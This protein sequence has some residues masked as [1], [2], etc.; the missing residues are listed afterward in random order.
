MKP[1]TSHHWIL[2]GPWYRWDPP[3]DPVVGRQA[4]PEIQKYASPDFVQ[5]FLKKPW[6]SLMWTDQDKVHHVAPT[7]GSKYALSQTVY[8]VLEP[9][10]RKI[11]LPTHSRFYLIV[12]ELHCDRPG[13]PSVRR[14]C[15]GQ[16][17]FV[18]RRWALRPVSPEERRQVEKALGQ[19]ADSNRKF[20]RAVR[21]AVAGQKAE[22]LTVEV[23]KDVQKVQSEL[24]RLAGKLALQGWKPPPDNKKKPAPDEDDPEPAVSWSWQAV[25]D[26]VPTAGTDEQIYPLY[27]LVPDPA[28]TNHTAAGRCIWFGVIPTGS[29]ELDVS[30]N[31]QY[32]DR[33][34]YEIRG[35][36]RPRVEGCPKGPK[37][38][39]AVWSEPTA[40]YQLASHCDLDG[41]S[42]QPVTVQMPDLDALAAQAASMPMGA[43]AGVKFVTPKNSM[44]QFGVD[45]DGKA[46]KKP[47]LG[48][49]AICGFAIPLITIVATFV[50]RLFLPIVVFLFG[51]WWMLRLRFCIP[52]V[53]MA[54]ADLTARLVGRINNGLDLDVENSGVTAALNAY[55]DP[56]VRAGLTGAYP[57]NWNVLGKLVVDM[58]TDFG[59]SA[60]ADLADTIDMPT[61]QGGPPG[62]LPSPTDGLVYYGYDP[63]KE[64]S[65]T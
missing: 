33:S 28:Q 14:E 65:S 18:V 62:S 6:R 36:V 58:S 46:E 35:F 39:E 56:S 9:E 59:G 10:T 25:G 51:L 2:T 57:N 60:P 16:A 20:E 31:P 1:K 55:P 42:H 61:G 17:G 44:L 47:G 54:D 7:G 24:D 41:T 13:F 3:G 23:A 48:G 53:L 12:F 27:P 37:L 26:P 43:G 52:P 64:V 38:G 5:Q 22:Q 30:G 21:M 29:R 32:D 50:L 19:L 63:R 15:V 34:L 8:Q 4:G 11:F 40:C 45:K 49:P